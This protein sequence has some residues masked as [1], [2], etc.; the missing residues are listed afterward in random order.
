MGQK[1]P[2]HFTNLVFFARSLSFHRH[3]CHMDFKGLA[4]KGKDQKNGA[5]QGGDECG[6]SL[7]LS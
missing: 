3:F 6:L 5:M 7:D 2:Q 4:A 1:L